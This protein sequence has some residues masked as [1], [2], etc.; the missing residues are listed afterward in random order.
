MTPPPTNADRA[1]AW[2]RV[3]VTG[4]TG[5]LGGRVARA[6]AACDAEVVGSGRDASAGDTLRADG[7]TFAPADL[8]DADAVR[9]VAAGAGLVIHCGAL[10][11]PWGPRAAFERA[12]VVGTENVVAACRA[13]GAALV[14]ISTPSVYADGR[15]RLG[16][17]ES[18]PFAARPANAY[19]RTKA[20]A[21]RVV[22][23]AVGQGLRAVIVRPRA[24]VGPGDTAIVPRLLRAADRGAVPLVGG[25]DALV[26]ATVVDNAADVCLA[27]AR[28]LLDGRIPSGRDY[29]VSD[30][31]PRP[32]WEVVA[33][34]GAALGRDLPTRRVPFGVAY[35]AAA[36]LEGIAAV[37]RREPLVTRYGIAVL[38][39]SVTLDSARARRELGWAP[40]RTLDDALAG[41]AE[42]AP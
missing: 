12:N 4:A 25:G 40:R 1:F 24:L 11:A 35:A 3:L 37:T 8:G 23:C 36:L 31:D 14:H 18:A 13:A 22:Q 32:L 21:E 6:L 41:Y 15:A 26:D 34:L 39:R 33:R 19:A 10:S 17:D 38:G 27:A 2:P 20:E 42:A 29:N 28:A 5:F 30:G 7:V 16:L 9:A